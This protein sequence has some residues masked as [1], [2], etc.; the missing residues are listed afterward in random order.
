MM[1]LPSAGIVPVIATYFE[2]LKIP[3]I[4]RRVVR[5]VR[6]ARLSARCDHNSSLI[7]LY[8]PNEDPIGRQ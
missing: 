8:L 6:H 5:P 7:D 3:L 2:T 1:D 4:R